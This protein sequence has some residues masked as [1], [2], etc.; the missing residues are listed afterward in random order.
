MKI[1][2]FYNKKVLVMGLGVNGGGL[3][4]AKFFSKIGAKVTVTDLK[5]EKELSSP[6][7]ALSDFPV[8][9]VLGRH[10]NS[11]FEDSDFIIQ[12]PAVSFDSPFVQ[13]ARKNGVVI[14]N[15]ISIFLKLTPSKNIIGITGTKGKTTTATLAGEMYKR[16]RSDTVLAG[17]LRVS[18][19]D[20][21]FKITPSTPI[22]LELSSFQLAGLTDYK[23]SPKI[24]VITSIFRDHLNR[25][26]DFN[27]YITDK[28]NILRFQNQKDIAIL[29]VGIKWDFR[30]V[31]MGGKFWFSNEIHRVA[32]AGIIEKGGSEILF[33]RRNKLLEE[34]CEVRDIKIRGRQVI[35][36]ILA[37][38]LASYLGG[39]EIPSIRETIKNFR[40]VE[41]RLEFVREVNGVS[42][43][44]DTTATI[45]DAVIAAIGSFTEPLILILG[46]N[47]KRL[48][49]VKLAN[50]IKRCSSYIKAI[51]F[52][53]GSA[54]FKMQ[55]VFTARGLQ[56]KTTGVFDN[57]EKAV[58]AAKKIAKKG[59]VV[60]LSPGATS[61]NMF[62]NEFERGEKFKEIIWGF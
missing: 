43:Y 7:S 39:V 51:V 13:T 32:H 27:S 2:D 52:L 58:M 33:L 28:K 24:A 42:Y 1:S 35:S 31:G 57:F 60:L 54:T 30:R 41:H 18:V 26:P 50:Y 55:R 29:P 9:F 17:N 59:E 3:G 15:E 8:R 10:E 16:K 36:N 53:K 47:D 5:S 44:N 23:F 56:S 4:V 49:F 25:Y 45:P 40:G 6:I 11:D 19:L 61:F 20:N 38:S 48:H 21:L 37:A 12:N 62:A 34:V 22:V 46:G 14:E